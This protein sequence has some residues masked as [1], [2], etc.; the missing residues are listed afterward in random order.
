[1][2]KQDF[3]FEFAPGSF[4]ALLSEG[5]NKLFFKTKICGSKS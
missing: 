2:P 4:I 1:M 3:D 5:V